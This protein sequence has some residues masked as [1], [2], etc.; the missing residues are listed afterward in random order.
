MV[1]KT[2][3]TFS[4]NGN[5]NQNQSCFRRTRFLA[6]GA[7]DMYLLRILIYTLGRLHLL[8]LARAITLVLL[9]DTRLKGQY[10]GKSVG[11]IMIFG[12]NSLNLNFERHLN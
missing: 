1:N 9:Y 10:H 4:T 6:L 7:S 11:V 2:S 5:P 3:A 8:R 12:Q